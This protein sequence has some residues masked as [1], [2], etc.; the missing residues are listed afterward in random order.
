MFWSISDNCYNVHQLSE[1]FEDTL[2]TAQRRQAS[3]EDL[4]LLEE[5]GPHLFVQWG[6]F[7]LFSG[8]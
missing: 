5:C 7:F 3:E 4:R 6:F 2:A 1:N 8:S